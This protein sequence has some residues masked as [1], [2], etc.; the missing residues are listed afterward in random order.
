MTKY[1]LN[2]KNHMRRPKHRQLL[3]EIES[4]K[5]EG[6]IPPRLHS[7]VIVEGNRIDKPIDQKQLNYKKKDKENTKKIKQ[8]RKFKVSKLL[9]SD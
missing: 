9:T 7:R 3:A 2:M 8:A 4:A 5:V 6:V 1:R